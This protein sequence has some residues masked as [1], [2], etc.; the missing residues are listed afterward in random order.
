MPVFSSMLADYSDYSH[1]DVVLELN[2]LQDKLNNQTIKIDTL[3]AM[4]EI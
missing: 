4:G 1:G 2:L 3:Q